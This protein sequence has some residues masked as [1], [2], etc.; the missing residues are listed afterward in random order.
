MRIPSLRIIGIEEGEECQLKNT[1][2]IVNKQNPR[3]LPQP[4]E[5]HLYKGKRSLHNIKEAGPEKK[6]SFQIIIKPL[7]I[8]TN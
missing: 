6:C 4:K 2:S 8:L 7:T 1:E 5:S 3:T